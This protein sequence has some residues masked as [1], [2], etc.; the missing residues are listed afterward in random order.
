MNWSGNVA[1]SEG[2]PSG[3]DSLFEGTFNG[4]GLD[5]DVSHV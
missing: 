3:D 1:M 5:I 2:K 4:N